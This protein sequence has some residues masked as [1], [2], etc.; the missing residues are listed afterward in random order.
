MSL[1]KI[2]LAINPFTNS[3][4]DALTLSMSPGGKVFEVLS[5]FFWG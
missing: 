3:L 4:Y 1:I 5:S 2:V